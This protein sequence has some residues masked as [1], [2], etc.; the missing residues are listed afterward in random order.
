MN[1]KVYEEV[2]TNIVLPPTQKSHIYLWKLINFDPKTQIQPNKQIKLKLS[3][4]DK[5]KFVSVQLEESF[6]EIYVLKRV[7]KL[8]LIK[9]TKKVGKFSLFCLLFDTFKGL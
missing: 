9:I 8:C 3:N 4:C 6:R 5:T 7:N 1:E 2:C